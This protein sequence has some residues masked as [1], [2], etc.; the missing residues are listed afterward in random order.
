[1]ADMIE[2]TL[3][4]ATPDPAQAATVAE[5]LARTAL[6]LSAEPDVVQ[7]STDIDRYPMTCV[8]DHEHDEVGP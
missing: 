4:V 8:H 5:V 2:L 7:V 6:G 3:R 1:M